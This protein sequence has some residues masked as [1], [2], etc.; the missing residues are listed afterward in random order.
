MAI[1]RLSQQSAVKVPKLDPNGIYFSNQLENIPPEEVRYIIDVPGFSDYERSLYPNL[2]NDDELASHNI[3]VLNKNSKLPHC[4]DSSFVRIPAPILIIPPNVGGFEIPGSYDY[5]RFGE[6]YGDAFIFT[7]KNYLKLNVNKVHGSLFF[8]FKGHHV[9]SDDSAYFEINELK[10]VSGNLSVIQ[11]RGFLFMKDIPV[12]VGGNVFIDSQD[13]SRESVIKLNSV[14][15]S[16]VAN[17]CRVYDK[18]CSLNDV[19][20]MNSILDSEYIFGDLI[21]SGNSQCSNLEGI[22]GNLTVNSPA[23]F[24]KLRSVEGSATLCTGM[25]LPNSCVVKNNVNEQNS[26]TTVQFA[27]NSKEHLVTENKRLK[28][29]VRKLESDLQ[30][31]RHRANEAETRASGL[32]QKLHL[33]GHTSVLW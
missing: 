9:E 12:S 20:L 10:E 7:D 14:G 11:R 16:L 18:G 22:G 29:Q 24:P 4:E 6:I 19:T 21:F 3:V 27:D 1:E 8:D 25:F 2:Y 31:A 23:V 13:P 26:L 5:W 17:S 28:E 33:H 32:A 30:S 15:G